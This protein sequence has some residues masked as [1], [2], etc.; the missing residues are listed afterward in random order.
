M[1]LLDWGIVAGLVLVLFVAALRTRKYTR[2]VSAF[3]VAERCGGR[4]IISMAHAMAGLGVISLVYWFE[5]YYEAGFTAY[6]W[7]AMTE[8]ALIVLALSGWVVYRFRQTRA[9]TLP[10]FFEMRYSRRFRVFAGLVAYLAGIINFGIFPAVGARFFIALC[11]LPNYFTLLGIEISTFVSLM[12]GLL[13]VSLVFT[14]LGGHIAVMVTDFLQ[15]VFANIVFALVIGYL[16]YS[17]EWDRMAEVMLQAPAEKSQVHPFHVGDQD[18]FGIGYFLISVVIVFYGVLGWQGTAGYNCCAK[19]AHEAKMAGI[20]NGWRFRVL[21]LVAIIVPLAVHAF[22]E[23]PDFGSQAA[24]VRQSLASI[25]ADSPKEAET[26]QTQLR[27]PYALAAMLPMGLLGLMC[28]A[29]LAAFLSTHDTYLHSWGAIFVQDVIMPFRKKK[30]TQRQHLWLLR[31]S[32]FGVAIFI[33]FF[34]LLYR[35]NQF[36]AM[37]LAI[38][39]AVFVGGAG[40]VIIGGLYWNRGT[41]QGAWAA[42]LT[43]STLS[44]SGIVIKQYWADWFP[45]DPDFFLTGQE[46]TFVAIVASVSMYILVSLFGPRRVHNMDKLL[47]RGEYNL[48]G[49][50]STS[51]KDARTWL[52]KLGLDR[53]FTGWDRFVTILSVGWPLVWTAIFIAGTAYCLIRKANGHEVSD[54]SWLSFWS[55]YTWIIYAASICVT[56]WFTI[57]GIKDLRYLFRTLRIRAADPDD[58]GSVEQESGEAAS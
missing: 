17:I 44:V 18:F 40:S 49:E 55:G 26:L 12:I 39:G 36:I 47:H 58:D 35:Q 16:L 14:F 53:E 34:S 43:G 28:A 21:L 57:G 52:E 6:W 1:H 32:I 13:S 5:M 27:T 15:G 25:E 3:L 30:L 19:D 22:L 9:M 24:E 51:F 31:L 7:G 20:L 56:I 46:M 4:Y 2:T 48:A 10:Q 54:E 29:M 45:E 23:H 33:F 8:P 37:F 38:T 50:S 41:T 11:G 42:M